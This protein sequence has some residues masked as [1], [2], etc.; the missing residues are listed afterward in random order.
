MDSPFIRV[1]ENRGR[2]T[3]GYTVPSGYLNG[4]VSGNYVALNLFEASASVSDGLFNFN[5]AYFT[6][7]WNDGLSIQIQG[8]N[9]ANLLY[10]QTIVVSAFGPNLFNA[11]YVGIDLLTFDSFG[12][13]PQPWGGSGTHFA[14]DNFDYTLGVPEPS[15]LLLLGTGLV[16]V[17]LKR[18]RQKR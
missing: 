2:F 13:T 17:G 11:N 3:A 12:G 5:N 1:Q 15:T 7:A 14:M 16:M 9:G 4:L 8:W 18:R 6:G 10:D